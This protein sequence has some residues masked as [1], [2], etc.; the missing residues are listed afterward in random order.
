MIELWTYKENRNYQRLY[1]TLSAALE[2]ARNELEA[3]NPIQIF[4]GREEE[5]P[6]C[7]P[8]WYE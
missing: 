8:C 6:N 4:P 2:A 5:D 1:G 3:G 7:D